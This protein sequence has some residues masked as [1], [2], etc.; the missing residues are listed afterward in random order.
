MPWFFNISKFTFNHVCC[1]LFLGEPETK[2][3]TVLNTSSTLAKCTSMVVLIVKPSYLTI[4]FFFERRKKGVDKITL[5]GKFTLERSMAIKNQFI[6]VYRTS[7][8]ALSVKFQDCCCNISRD[9]LDSEFYH[10]SCTV[11]HVITFLICIIHIR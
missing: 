10:L 11:Y 5:E 4:T 6:L 7:F 9:I 1:Q 8:Y 3:K 2:M